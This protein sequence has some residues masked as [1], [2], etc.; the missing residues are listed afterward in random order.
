MVRR[1]PFRRGK[2]V[3]RTGLWAV[4]VL[5]F[6]ACPSSYP[7]QNRLPNLKLVRP[8]GWSDAMVVS[9]RQEATIDTL[10]LMASDRLYLDFAV[11]NSGGSPVTE[12]FRI[13]LFLDGRLRE[14]FD[15]ADPL[16]PQIYRFREDYPLGRLSS[17]TH[18][19]RI[20]VDGGEAVP[21]SDESDNQYTKTIVVSG[22]CFPL[23]PRVSPRGAGTLTPSQ[24]PNCGGATFSVRGLSVRDDELDQELGTAGE[25]ILKAQRERAFAA[26]RAKIHA[27]GKVRVIVGLR[28]E[29]RSVV[30]AVSNLNE[31]EDRSPL[32]SQAQQSF[33]VRMSSYNLASVRRFKYIPHVAMEVDE[34]ALEALA[35]DPEV[36]SIEEDI[37]VKPVLEESTSLVGAP[38]AWSQGYAGS[39]QTVVVLDTGVDGN[40]PFLKDKVVSEACYSGAEEL[41]FPLCP[42]GVREATGLESGM[43]CSLPDCFHGTAVAGVAAGKGTKFSGVAP[44]A[45]IIAVQVFSDCGGAFNCLVTSTS[46]WVAGLERVLELS[47]GL[48]IAA[49]NMSFGGGLFSEDCDLDFPAVKAAMDNL[50]TFGIAP[51]VASGNNGSST[52]IGFPACISSAVSVGSTDTSTDETTADAVSNF[53]NSSPLLDL[54]APGR[55]ITTSVP[56]ESFRPYSG[57]S[58][59]APHV[60]GGWAVLKSKAPNASVPELLSALKN[61]GVPI[62][63]PRNNLIKPRIQVD[64]A[65]DKIVQ[66]LPYSSGT[67]LTLTARPNPGFRFRSWQG[68]DSF[69]GNRCIVEM[70]SVKNVV[71]FFEPTAAARP[72]LITTSVVAPPTATAGNQA[73]IYAA[74]GNQGLVD[75]GPFR[76]GFY[77]SIDDTI[78]TDDTWFAACWFD[79]GVAAG[80]SATCN[81]LFPLPPR[82]SPGT[83][84]L[85]AIVDDLD[86]VAEASE[87]NNAM[88]ANSGTIEVIV[89]IISSRS[90]IP[91]V[92]SAAGLSDSFFTSELTLTNRGADEAKLDYIYRAH[93]GGGS[94]TASDVLAP[95]QQKIVPDTLDYLKSL[96]LPVPGSGNRIG[97]LGVEAVGFSEVGVVV[98][99]TTAVAEGRAGLAYPGIDGDEGFQ[100]AV[101]LCGLRQNAQD[102]SNVAFQN[103][104]TTADGAITLRTTVFSGDPAAPSVTVLEDVRLGPGGFHQYSG[105]LGSVTNGYVKVERVDGTAPFYAYGVINEQANS[106]GSFVFPVTESSLAGTTGQTLP[107][108][109]ETGVFNSELTLT[110]F[111]EVAKTIN[112]SFVADAIQTE[113]RTAHFSLTLET[114]EQRIVPNVVDQL[115]QQG[116]EGVSARRAYAG[117]VFARVDGGDMSGIVI[118]A[119]TG[120]SG[121]GGQYS[122]FYNAVPYGAAFRDSAWVDALQQNAE[123]RSN[124][125]LVNTGELDDSESVFSLDIYDGD[126]GNLVKTVRNIR[127]P[128]RRWRQINSIL[129]DYAPGTRQGYAQIRKVSGNNPFLAYGIINDG[130][131]PGQRSGDGAY[132]PARE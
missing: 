114:G 96:G 67:R 124:L 102:R 22:A 3:S 6:L 127:V 32:I 24:D 19:L 64:A 9:N 20:V 26:L 130:G 46:D 109:V 43:P 117:P 56:G 84:F 41:L 73:S 111:S 13:E 25:P 131:A 91:V 92:L 126:S 89:P 116:V 122:V 132:I 33:L 103:M 45:R 120:S 97:T 59:S 121:G 104:G 128:A 125:A 74:I 42:G 107:V 66:E 105:L 15:V 61:T 50:R 85:G 106:D 35:L 63:D 98:R 115:R 34:A 44:E 94:G 51:I 65:L 87:A 77:L 18:T 99:T 55:R 16:D 83:Y 68:C 31:A 108:I 49:V 110:N 30:A 29:G 1:E 78:T 71:A 95:G 47:A 88:A 62:I 38:H 7:S 28:T 53:S 11:I 100:E 75:A 40:H 129:A 101:Y 86:Q 12:P 14:T 119:R 23:I 57:T 17:G 72:D 70:G 2:N 21:E 54:L 39:D 58:L 4:V 79:S 60:A 5:L 8:E 76:L 81:R 37:V 48:D 36:L 10:R 82:V 123:N 118:G 52:R 80:E 69:S 90:F 113:D 27:E 112:F 93:I